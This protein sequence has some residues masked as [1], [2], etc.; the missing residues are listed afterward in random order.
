MRESVLG[1]AFFDA[2]AHELRP[3]RVRVRLADGDAGRRVWPGGAVADPVAGLLVR[4]M[5]L[6]A[7]GRRG[8]GGRRRSG[9]LGAGGPVPPAPSRAAAA[10][11]APG[12]PP[13]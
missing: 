7:T 8:G 12:P 4:R 5:P 10:S 6:S 2:G 9:G 3:P 13:G 1:P 11:R